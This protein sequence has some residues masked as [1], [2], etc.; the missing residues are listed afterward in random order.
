MRK[1][2][3]AEDNF[4]HI[5]CRGTE[6]RKIFNSDYDRI[7][8]I[9]AFY[10]CNN[11]LTIPQRFDLIKLEPFED[12][13]PTEPNIEV[14]AG[15]L[16]DNHY[17]FVVKPNAK[18]GISKVFQRLGT[19]YTMYFNKINERAGRL[20]ETPFQAK[21]I[22]R[23]NYANYITQ[24][25]H[26]NPANLNQARPGSNGD[27]LLKK[28]ESYEW[29]TLPDYLGRK[30]RL[31]ILLPKGNSTKFRDEILNMGVE[32]YCKFLYELFRDRRR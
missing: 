3:F 14:A 28:I 8:F 9:H 30:S 11:F 20:F 19:S 1:V 13:V 12:L 4:Y 29:S 31:S 25:I 6:K 16:M 22:D 21:H 17:H 26:L 32:E 18:E 23:Q 15:C 5:Y 7:R 10:V 27:N 2:V 24:Y